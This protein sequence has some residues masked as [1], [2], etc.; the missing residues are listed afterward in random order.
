MNSMYEQ[1]E[2]DVE[3]E[4]SGVWLD[5]GAFRV[6]IARAGGSNKPYQKAM[7]RISRSHRH[8]I[9]ADTLDAELADDLVRRVFA[10]TVI[11]EWESKVDDEFMSGIEQKDSDE[12]L[13]FSRE[14]VLLTLRALPT[15]S[16][17]I[18]AQARGIA[19]FRSAL[20]DEISG[21]L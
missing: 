20:R 1:F 21:N 16:E 18:Q 15:I 14:N 17:D 2:T 3:R 10:Q 4:K 5:Y 13:P 12:L 19:L 11:L 7:E 9:S 6:K 8:A